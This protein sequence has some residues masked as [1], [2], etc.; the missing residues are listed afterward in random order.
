MATLTLRSIKGTPLTTAELDGNF[1]ALNTELGQKVSSFNSRTGPVSLT[2]GDV[3]AALGFTPLAANQTITLSGDVTGSG[4]TSITA[5]LP[6]TGVAAG[7]Y[8]N[9]NLTVDAKGRITAV[10]NGTAGGV[11]TFNTRSGAVSLTSADVTTALGFTPI[12]SS[13]ASVIEVNSSSAALRITQTNPDASPFSVDAAGN[14]IA[15]NPT[16]ISTY[17]DAQ[18]TTARTVKVQVHG[19]HSAEGIAITSWANTTTGLYYSAALTLARSG[20]A[21]RGTQ[22]AVVD[23]MPLGSLVYSGD[24]GTAFIKAA[25]IDV[26]VDG[27]PGTGSM[28]G[29]LSLSTTPSGSSTP[30]ERVRLTAAGLLGVGGT[31][32]PQAYVDNRGNRGPTNGTVL[33][34]YSSAFTAS[35][36]ST[37]SA[38]SFVSF[39]GP[40]TGVALTTMTHY[41][42]AQRTMS[43]TV[44]TQTGFEVA[45]SLTGATTNYGFRGRIASGTDRWNLYMDGTAAN[46]LAGATIFNNAIGL[47]TTSSPNYGTAG[48][49]LTS[50]GPGAV[51]TWSSASGGGSAISVSDEGSLLTSGVTSFNFVGSGVTA[52]AATNAVTVTIPGG[53]AGA[54]T[55]LESLRT[56]SSNYTITDGYNGSSVG[57]VTVSSGVAVTVNTGQR[58]LI[59]G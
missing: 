13:S 27:T 21:T 24:D 5:T 53:G 10:A 45:A 51:P 40:G 37:T 43:G 54:A 7:S 34:A 42:A 47:G 2:T 31:T 57:P 58:W 18:T 15:G 29:R 12:S 9:A 44:T 3:T 33:D 25:R 50:S 46:Y 36:V 52:T 38:T 55:I 14:V 28:P 19:A 41:A 17:H 20:S 59:L 11:T 30:V 22:A 16:A 39:I 1:T 48:Q 8:T 6:N 32:G 26:H 35:D 49:V 23:A 4:S 56:I